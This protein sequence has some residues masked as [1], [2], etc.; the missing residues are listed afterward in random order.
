MEINLLPPHFP[1]LKNVTSKNGITKKKL[2]G[3][4]GKTQKS[5]KSET[6][7]VKLLQLFLF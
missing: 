5:R 6:C 3:G 1:F 7:Y 4:E 2:C